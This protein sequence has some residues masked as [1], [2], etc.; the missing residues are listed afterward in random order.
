MSTMIDAVQEYF[1]D[2][3]PELCVDIRSVNVDPPHSHSD[4]E[5]S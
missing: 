2:K 3:H 1:D 4:V 5:L